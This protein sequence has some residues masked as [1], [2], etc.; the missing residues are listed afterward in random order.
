MTSVGPLGRRRE[1]GL[2][3]GEIFEL[4]GNE[5][6]RGVIHFLKRRDERVRVDELVDAVVEWERG[7]GSSRDS[8]YSSLV[9]THLPR[10]DEAGV[11]EYDDGGKVVRPTEHVAEMQLYLEYSP[12]HD[13]PWPEYYLGLGAVAAGLVT[14]VW[15]GAPPFEGV[16][17]VTVA[18]VVSGAL[19][20]S[21]VVHVLQARRRR[22]GDDR[23]DDARDDAA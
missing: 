7:V 23:L 18:A 8:V 19:V 20:A 6:R 4:L 14:A 17:G 12:R 3:P 10:L 22:L 2:P 5:R 13:I 16:A 9:Q 1:R 21:A 15:L 11:V